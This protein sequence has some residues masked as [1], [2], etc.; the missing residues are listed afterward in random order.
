MTLLSKNLNPL[1]KKDITLY[2]LCKTINTLNINV[3]KNILNLV[4]KFIKNNTNFKT[5]NLHIQINF[6]FDETVKNKWFK[7]N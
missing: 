6:N 1:I 2:F 4:N 5:G 3:E 7:V